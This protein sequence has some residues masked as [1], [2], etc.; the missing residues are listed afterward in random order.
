MRYYDP[1]KRAGFIEP[2]G[3]GPLL[4]FHERSLADQQMVPRKGVAV[5]FD[6]I[7]DRTHKSVAV[8]IRTIAGNEKAAALRGSPVA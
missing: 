4:W 7:T 3:G 1:T 6:V 5:S 2:G 8:Q